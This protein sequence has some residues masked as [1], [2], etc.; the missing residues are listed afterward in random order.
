MPP[1]LL[2]LSQLSRISPLKHRG[3]H[4]FLYPQ[5]QVHTSILPRF[6]RRP[7]HS[8]H[9]HQ[10]HPSAS[11]SQKTSPSESSTNPAL[12]SLNLT[13]LGATRTVKIVVLL[14]LVVFGTMETVFYAKALWRYFVPPEPAAPS[15]S[16]NSS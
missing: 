8:Q 1:T 11:Q 6:I 13:D 4:F 14:A 7:V 9:Q 12:P 2:V 5:T 16:E 3:E 10:N 15:S